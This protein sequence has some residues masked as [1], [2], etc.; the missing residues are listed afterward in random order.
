MPERKEAVTD[1]Q[2]QLQALRPILLTRNHNSYLDPFDEFMEQREFGL[3][4]HAVCDFILEPD[5]L[6]LDRHTLQQIR[7]LHMVMQIDDHCVDELEK[8]KLA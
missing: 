1:L 8:H 4:L 5:S 6:P 3:A 7:T 2:A